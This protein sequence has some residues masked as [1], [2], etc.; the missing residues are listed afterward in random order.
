MITD[1]HLRHH[2]VYVEG[3]LIFIV[4]YK[5][6]Y[7]YFLHFK[8]VTIPIDHYSYFPIILNKLSTYLCKPES[9]L[10]L[11]CKLQQWKY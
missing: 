5:C 3:E 2:Y 7:F 4:H 11:F 8:S 6:D 10:Q 9:C 1:H